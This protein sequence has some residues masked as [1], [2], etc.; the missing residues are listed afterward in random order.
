[1]Y[2]ST[3]SNFLPNCHL[4]PLVIA[5]DTYVPNRRHSLVLARSASVDWWSQ[6]PSEE[7]PNPL[8]KKIRPE[9]IFTVQLT[10]EYSTL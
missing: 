5:L 7:V 2:N 6:V 1:M 9:T 10:M 4:D 8:H 3:E